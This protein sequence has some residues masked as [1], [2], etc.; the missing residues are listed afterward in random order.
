MA[1]TTYEEIVTHYTSPTLVLA[2]PGA[3]KTHLLADRVKR[4]LEKGVDKTSITVLTFGTDAKQHMRDELTT[5]KK[6]FKIEFTNLPHISTMHSLGLGIVY[7]KPRHVNLLKTNLTVQDD[8]YIKKLLYRDAAFILGLGEQSSQDAFECKLHGDCEGAHEEAECKIC[9]KYWEIMSK[10]NCIDFDDQILFACK[11]LENNPDLLERYQSQSEHLLVDE[12]Q[13]INAA[14]FK[15]IDLLSR[16]SRSGLFVV[17]DDAQSIYGFRGADPSF[18]LHFPEDFPGAEAP[19]LAYSRRCHKT[20]MEDAFK[21]VEKY[22]TDWKGNKDLHYIKEAGEEPFIWQFPSENAEAEMVAKIARSV[23]PEK[24]VLVL[25][26][27]KEFFTE[28]SEALCRHNVPHDCP[29]A[30]PERIEIAKQIIDWAKNPSDNLSTRV[31]IEH[32]INNKG[33]AKVAGAKKN[34][35]CSPETIRKRNAAEAEIAT[36]WESVDKENNLFSVIKALEEPKGTLQKLQESLLRIEDSFNNYEKEKRGD[37]LKN[38]AVVVGIWGDPGDFAKDISAVVKTVS[39]EKPT[40]PGSVEIKTMR[41]AKGLEA[42]VV[43]IVGLEDDIVP[44]PRND[45][46][47]ESRLF[48]VSMTRAKEKL[49]LFH[50]Y[51][52]P[53]NI[54]YGQDLIDKP[55]SRFLDVIGRK[56]KYIDPK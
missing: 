48:Y 50:S 26:P 24:S 44:A 37:F 3:G 9:N 56:S 4:L 46:V 27:K 11:I 29:S 34:K 28:I 18:I 33:I 2:G 5:Q 30:L 1:L 20:I 51:K 17:G 42:D 55:R 16:K 49:F 52:R 35:K 21:V 31:V 36:L 43:I 23:I 6:P 7:E 53:R 54:S 41:K 12:Y 32:L 19:P 8:A 38:I 40:G 39:S 13:D 22:Y 45:I 10:I 25:A 14:Q 15:L 47:E